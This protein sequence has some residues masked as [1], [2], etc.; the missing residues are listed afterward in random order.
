MMSREI[1]ISQA[2]VEA[3][4]DSRHRGETQ[5]GGP[6]PR[7][8]TPSRWPGG[9]LAALIS[10]R[11]L[12][13]CPRSASFVSPPVFSGLTWL[14]A[15]FLQAREGEKEESSNVRTSTQRV[16]RN[17]GIRIPL[18]TCSTKQRPARFQQ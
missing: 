12:I 5:D 6:R 18:R 4:D 2:A 14:C 15:L 9:G 11:Y 7:Y 3:V 10:R 8:L 13:S 16:C 17:Q 1:A